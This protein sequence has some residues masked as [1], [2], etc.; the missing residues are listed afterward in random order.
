MN[1]LLI[2]PWICDFSAYDLWSKPL[3]LLRI[4]SFLKRLK[5]KV[6]LIDCLD[7]F[8]P[9][10]DKFLNSRPLTKSTSGSG[11][12]YSEVIEKPYIFKDI[13]RRYKRYGLPI[14]IFEKLLRETK[15]PDIIL[16]TSGMSYWYLGVFEAIKILKKRFPSV[17]IILGGIYANICF[18]HAVKNSNA[19]FVYRGTDIKEILGAISKLT[20]EEFDYSLIKKENLYLAYELYP[21][22][23]YITLRTSSGCPFKC[24][25][26][27]WYLLDD[28][29]KQEDPDF[30]ISEI[31][32]FYNKFRIRDFSL[33]DDA[34]LYRAEDHIVKIL[35]GLVKKKIKA[36]FHTPNGLHVRYINEKLAKLLR[37]TGFIQPRLGLETTNEERQIVTGGKATNKE[38]LKAIECLR[39]AGYSS[40]EIGVYI[41][42]GI[43]GQSI[44]EMEETVKFLSSCRVRIFLEEY[45]PIPNTPD[46]KRSGLMPDADPLFHNNIAFSY[47]YGQDRLHEVKDLV[48]RLNKR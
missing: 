43:P 11:S 26:C 37:E 19:D 40:K 36:F 16:V 15:R 6:S 39:E 34:L 30:V 42:A 46:Y 38:F 32:Y 33:Y 25:Y 35:H 20:E 3:G 45:S 24:S 23:A 1:A 5:V 21:K 41:M 4:A 13:P 28:R 29:L 12:Y 44:E 8:H 7:R 31:E 22:L 18:D 48:H 10:L 27:G 17:P 2:N 47:L 14:E 9:Q